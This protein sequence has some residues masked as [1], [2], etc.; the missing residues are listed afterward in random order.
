[1]NDLVAADLVHH[2]AIEAIELDHDR[3]ERLNH[4]VAG[5]AVR[6]GE[7]IEVVHLLTPRLELGVGGGN[8]LPESNYR[9]IRHELTDTLKGLHA[10]LRIRG[11]APEALIS[12]SLDH[13][14]GL[15][16]TSADVDSAGGATVVNSNLLE[17]WIEST[18]RRHHGVASAVTER[19]SPSA[20]VTYLGHWPKCSGET[21]VA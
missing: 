11:V 4:V 16:A 9:G 10:K 13:L 1:M 19:R 15:E 8:G 17:V 6:N 7:D 2:L 21:G 14:A 18:I 20:Y 12:S 5:V 3:L